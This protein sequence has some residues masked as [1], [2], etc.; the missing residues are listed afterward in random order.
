M[1]TVTFVYTDGITY[2]ATNVQHIEKQDS[3]I[4]YTQ[5]VINESGTVGGINLRAVDLSDLLYA[6]VKNQETKEVTIIPGIFDNFEVVPKGVAV[7]RQ[8]NI[9]AEAARIAAD[10]AAKAPEREAKE[11]AKYEQRRK[12]RKEAWEAEHG[13]KAANVA[14][15]PAPAPTGATEETADTGVFAALSAAGINER[16]MSVLRDLLK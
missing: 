2:K 1:N 15:A 12:A 9:E 4:E 10:R 16:D 3:V 7:Q 5:S 13:V 6:V 8:A 14:P 11:K